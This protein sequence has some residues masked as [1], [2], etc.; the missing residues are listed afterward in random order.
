MCVHVCV[1]LEYEKISYA[2][3]LEGCQH[4]KLKTHAYTYSSVMTTDI[5]YVN[6]HSCTDCSYQSPEQNSSVSTASV[7]P[8]TFDLMAVSTL[9]LQRPV[10]QL[11]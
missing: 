3:G 1:H 8:E 5:C 11:L 10:S 9:S 7:P 2:G 6:C 4:L